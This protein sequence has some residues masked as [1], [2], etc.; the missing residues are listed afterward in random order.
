MEAFLT[1]VLWLWSLTVAQPEAAS[2]R[3][4]QLVKTMSLE[5]KVGQLMMIGIPGRELD[6]ATSKL[7]RDLHV[8]AVA[9]FGFNIKSN[10]QLVRLIGDIRKNLSD[11]V[12]PFIALDQEG[13]N[14]VRVRSEVAVLPGAMVLGATRDPVL[15]FLA[16]QANGVDLRLLGVDM[17]LAPVLDIN[18]NPKNPVINVRAIG[19]YPQ[20][21]SSLGL[22]YIQG[23]QQAE[24]ATVAKHFPG[25]GTTAKDSHFSLPTLHLTEEELWAS[26]IP[27]FLDAVQNGLDAIMMAHVQVPALEPSGLPA[28]LSPKII[29]G[30]LRGKM[31][32]DGVVITDDMEMRAIEASRDVGKVAVLAIQ[33]GADMVMTIWTAQK[34]QRIQRSLLQA[35]QSGAISAERLDESVRRI[36]RLKEKRGSLDSLSRPQPNLSQYLPNPYHEQLIRAIALRGITLVRNEGNAIPICQGKKVLVA[37]PVGVF[38]K[39][40]KALLPEATFLPI[41]LVPNQKTRDAELARIRELGRRY[42][43]VVVAVVNAYQAWMVQQ[44]AHWLKTPLVVVSLGSPYFLRNFPSVSGYVCAYSSQP[45]VQRAAAQALGGQTSISGRLPVSINDRYPRGHGLVLSGASCLKE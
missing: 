26:E 21:V 13:G 42:R 32:F 39:E 9:L 29:T 14:V 22:A 34:K 23:Q 15:A 16:G 3:V 27:P 44:L 24:M 40:L 30:L 41:T 11:D 33:A 12:Q 17:N 43:L 8:G 45:S 1:K 38:L 7:L 6:R 19:D 18:R 20:L 10:A 28:S 37:T 2:A 35:V 25:H 5:Q 36:L 4:E 31:G